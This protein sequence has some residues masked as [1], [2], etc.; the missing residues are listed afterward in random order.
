MSGLGA[1]VLTALWVGL[2]S[3]AFNGVDNADGAAAGLAT[4]SSVVTFSI[5][6]ATWQYDLATLALVLGG[7]CLGFLVFNFPRPRATIFLGDSGSLFLGFGVAVFTI[8]GEWTSIG[9]KSAVIAALL[10]FVPLFD[11]LF[12]IVSRGL[13]GRYKSWEDPIRM[14]G[15]DHTYHRLRYL[16]LSPLQCLCVLYGLGAMGGWSAFQGCL[17]PDFLSPQRLGYG[18]LTVLLI[19]VGLKMIPLPADAFHED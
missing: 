5:A 17:N 3:S 12:I 8:L 16:G 15:R 2:V 11:F 19:S 6:W 4:L 13:D 9:W 18:L 14:C 1:L 7:S 10:V